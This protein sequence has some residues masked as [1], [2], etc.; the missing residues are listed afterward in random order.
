MKKIPI[1]PSLDRVPS[2]LRTLMEGVPL[3]D[4]SCS[5]EARVILIDRD[6]GY[7]LKCAS[8]GSL[9]S[10]ETMTRYFHRKG[11]GTEVLLYQSAEE[12][13]LLTRRVRGEDCTHT[14]YVEDPER[15]C[16]TVAT[17]LRQLHETDFS[18][19]PVQNRNE[20][21]FS[22]AEKNHALG[23]YDASLFC[24]D[25]QFSS[26]DEAWVVAQQG[27][28]YFQ[29]NVLLHGDYCLPN[30]IL[31]DWH[32]SGMIDLGNGGVGERHID[33]FWGIWT[34]WFNLKTDRY[35]GRFLDAYGRDL[36]EP[37]MLRSIAA[38]EVFG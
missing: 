20:S 34:L 33:L 17:L 3:Y 5:P 25:W 7:F 28:Q 9:A 1:S 36:A 26:S 31:E 15:L 29:S 38:F 37:E 27:K 19:C 11:L 23:R 35:S 16:D 13:W 2:E 6:G 22:T 8:R 12:D 32:L 10:E 30:V 14:R 18:D 4:S 24:G 21:F